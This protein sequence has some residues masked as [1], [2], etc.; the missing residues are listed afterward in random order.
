MVPGVPVTVIMEMAV[1][2][3][4]PWTTLKLAGTSAMVKFA[5]GGAVTVTVTVTAAERAPEVPLTVN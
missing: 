1:A 5:G 2:P 3:W 4:P